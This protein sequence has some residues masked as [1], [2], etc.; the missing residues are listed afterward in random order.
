MGFRTFKWIGEVK[1]RTKQTLEYRHLILKLSNSETNETQIAEATLFLN[2]YRD[3]ILRLSRFPN[4]EKVLLQS[5][6]KKR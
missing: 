3:E 5:K 2:Q 1:P 4:V 6:A